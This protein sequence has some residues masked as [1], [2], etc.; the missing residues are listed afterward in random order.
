MECQRIIHDPMWFRQCMSVITG[1]V[2]YILLRVVVLI[3]EY[4]FEKDVIL[5][6]IYKWN[7]IQL[8]HVVQIWRSDNCYN[9]IRLI[10]D[11]HEY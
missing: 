11:V 2:I 9:N 7:I 8:N 6:Q 10:R 5:K 1:K 4:I 3:T